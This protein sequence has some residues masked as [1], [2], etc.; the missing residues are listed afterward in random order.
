MAGVNKVTL[1]GNIGKDPE[2]KH[3]D[4]GRAVATFSL[5]TNEVYKNK[6]GEKVENTQWHNI[7]ALSPFAEIVEKF[8]KKG[9]QIYIEGK[10]T[11][12]SWEDQSGQKRYTTEV[13]VRE[14]TLLNN[15][16]NPN[17]PPEHTEQDAPDWLNSPGSPED[18]DDLVF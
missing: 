6:Q 3:L 1:V 4:N 8:T 14:L 5:A 11:T 7:V 17:R 2:L 18:P 13:V 9:H 12:R 10:L 16:T 15:G